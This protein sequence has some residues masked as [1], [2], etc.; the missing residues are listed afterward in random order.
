VDCGCPHQTGLSTLVQHYISSVTT[1]V[2]LETSQSRQSV[3]TTNSQYPKE[4]SYKNTKLNPT[5]NNLFN[6]WNSWIN[7]KMHW[8]TRF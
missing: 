1:L 8:I 5:T 2:N 3:A 6:T 7:N 4:N